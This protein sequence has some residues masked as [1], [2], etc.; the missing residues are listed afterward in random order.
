MLRP[1]SCALAPGRTVIGP[2][3]KRSRWQ[4]AGE[5]GEQLASVS[6]GAPSPSVGSSALAAAGRSKAANASRVAVRRPWLT[7]MA[8]TICPEVGRIR[9]DP[10]ASAQARLDPIDAG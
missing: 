9:E 8:S 1:I 5:P 2:Y 6:C 4:P 3:A 10:G 7:D